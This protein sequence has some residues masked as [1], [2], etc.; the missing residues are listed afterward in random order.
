M[1]SLLLAAVAVTAVAAIPA[2]ATEYWSR[3][4]A[5]MTQQDMAIFEMNKVECADFAARHA[6]TV[7]T[8]SDP[9]GAEWWVTPF[10][11]QVPHVQFNVTRAKEL[12]ATCL[13]AK[14]YEPQRPLTDAESRRAGLTPKRYVR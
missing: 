11:Q 12:I 10:G 14:G 9:T 1:K 8:Y 2:H 5:A 13:R 4:G 6:G 7:V 3:P